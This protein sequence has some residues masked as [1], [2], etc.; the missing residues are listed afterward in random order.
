MKI[1]VHGILI[2]DTVFLLDRQFNNGCAYS[3]EACYETVGGAGNVIR[4]L[5][6]VMCQDDITFCGLVSENEFDFKYW[7]SGYCTKPTIFLATQ[8]SQATIIIDS[9]GEKTSVVNWGDDTLYKLTKPKADWHHI[10]YLDKVPFITPS[11]LSKLSGIVS[12]DLCD[13]WRDIEKYLPFIDYLF[14]SDHELSDDLVEYFGK[15]VRNTVLKHDF[16]GTSWSNGGPLKR[17]ECKP[18]RWEQN[19]LG[20]GDYYAA[21]FIAG[22]AKDIEDRIL[23]AHHTVIDNLGKKEVIQ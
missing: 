11:A 23:S 13:A 20:A 18:Y 6:R 1:A 5:K 4:F 16:H 8:S 17:V 10:A 19:C 12:V 2:R 3:A 7:L 15:K 22:T 14:V 9:F 21:A